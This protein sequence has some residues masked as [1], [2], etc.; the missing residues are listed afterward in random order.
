[1]KSLIFPRL[2]KPSRE[3]YTH[4]RTT[5][6]LEAF[7]RYFNLYVSNRQRIEALFC[8]KNSL[9]FL[10]LYLTVGENAFTIV[11]LSALHA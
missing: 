4:L 1:M 5:E 11:N 6:Q 3:S 9:I 2:S 8:Y 10:L 7:V